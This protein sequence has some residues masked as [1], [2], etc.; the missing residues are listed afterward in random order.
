MTARVASVV[1]GALATAGVILACS[2]RD[3]S[4]LKSGGEPTPEDGL[5][6]VGTPTGDGGATRKA[7]IAVPN[8]LTPRLLAQDTD[9]LYWITNDGSLWA[10][11]K[12]GSTAEPRLVATIGQGAT[13]LAAEEG[14]SLTHAHIERAIRMEFREIGKL[15]ET[16]VLE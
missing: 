2:L 16:G 4:Y 3:T 11:K 6:E 15:A 8:Q 5:A 1:L 12:D 14:V 13:F 7:T 9:T 10:F